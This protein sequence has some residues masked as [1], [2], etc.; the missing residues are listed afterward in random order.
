MRL[1]GPVYESLPFAYA[2]IGGLALSLAYLDSESPR[3]TVALLIGLL[4]EIAAVTVGLRRHDYRELRRVYNGETI[5]FPS[6]LNR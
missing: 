6:R 5:E 3:S 4:A 2:V 1:A